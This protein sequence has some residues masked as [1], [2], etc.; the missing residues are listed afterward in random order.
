M[1]CIV[2]PS[3]RFLYYK[4]EYYA[5][6]GR[7]AH[8]F[9]SR[10]LD[11]YSSTYLLARVCESLTQPPK[12]HLVSKDGVSLIGLKS[13]GVDGIRQLRRELA[14]WLRAN[15]GA[16][17]LRSPFWDADLGALSL[18]R[19]PPISVE[20][21]GNPFEVA[22]AMRLESQIR[23]MVLVA[24]ALATRRSVSQA[25]SVAYVSKSS[26]APLFPA[27]HARQVA[28]FSSINLCDSDFVEHSW[29]KRRE[30]NPRLITIAGLDQRYKGVEDL[31]EAVRLLADTGY[32]VRLDVVGDGRLRS[33]Y[34]A[35]TSRSGLEHLIGF[36]GQVSPDEIKSY[37]DAS[38]CFVL[39]SWTEGL[40]RALLEAMSRGLPCVATRVGG[41]ADI[42]P[43][44]VLV[45]PRDPEMLASR[46][47][48]ITSNPTASAAHGWTNLR[49]SRDFHGAVVSHE[50]RRYYMNHSHYTQEHW[51]EVSDG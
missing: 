45:D 17:F 25:M 38:D 9:W 49:R 3:A 28:E 44:E 19:R 43:A 29:S 35:L 10:Y 7:L 47:A 50:R 24:G 8:T 30:R 1:K 20:L 5:R 2:L 12:E 6:N 22:R 33:W 40:P 31:I 34:Q 36:K 41:T 4:G 32:R 26:L 46:I 27:T 18:K 16:L 13:G 23:G 51:N 37:L 21:V 14:V 11:V 42:L 15:R 39:A 48:Q